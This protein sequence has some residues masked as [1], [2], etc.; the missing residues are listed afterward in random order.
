MLSILAGSPMINDICTNPDEPVSFMQDKNKSIYNQKFK[1]IQLRAYKNIS[2]FISSSSKAKTFSKIINITKKLNWKILNLNEEKYYLHAVATTPL[3]RFKDDIAIQVE[4][5]PDCDNNLN[6]ST[7]ND[8]S[9]I[10]QMRS[11]SRLGKGDLG[12]NAKRI[13]NFFRLL[14]E[15]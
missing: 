14:K 9:C 5:I 6:K 12:A 8:N 11:K 1:N 13:N 4:S 3:M 2:P 10:V 7:N 15:Q